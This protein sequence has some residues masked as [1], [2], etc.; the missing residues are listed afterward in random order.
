[1][2]NRYSKKV[3]FII[4]IDM[5][6]AVLALFIHSINAVMECPSYPLGFG[7][8]NGMIEFSAVDISNDG[9]KVGIGGEC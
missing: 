9:T 1:M 7:G 8:T 2:F 6:S 5:K 4:I 3:I